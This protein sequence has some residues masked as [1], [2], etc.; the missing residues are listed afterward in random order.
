VNVPSASGAS[1]GMA[2]TCTVDLEIMASILRA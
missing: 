2:K 1:V